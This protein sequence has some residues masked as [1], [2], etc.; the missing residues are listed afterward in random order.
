MWKKEKSPVSWGWKQRQQHVNS[1]HNKYLRCYSHSQPLWEPQSC[2]SVLYLCNWV[3]SFF[4]LFFYRVIDQKKNW[5]DWKQLC[6][7]QS[8]LLNPPQRRVSFT[9]N[10]TLWLLVVHWANDHFLHLPL[11]SPL[12]LHSAES[13]HIFTQ[14][15]QKLNKDRHKDKGDDPCV[16]ETVSMSLWARFTQNTQTEKI[17]KEKLQCK[18]T[19][20]RHDYSKHILGAVVFSPCWCPNSENLHI[21]CLCCHK[22]SVRLTLV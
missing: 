10:H 7:L 21:L 14:T 13:T 16:N 15:P 18:N 17:T 2:S 22:R 1:L 9:P 12:L 11:S 20:M 5:R 8:R 19:S 4:F 6:C 3:F